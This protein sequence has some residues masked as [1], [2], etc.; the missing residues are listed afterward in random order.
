V[1]FP[2]SDLRDIMFT[3]QMNSHTTDTTIQKQNTLG[4]GIT[5]N[6]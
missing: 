6:W 2:P 4:A 3:G 1:K 5:I